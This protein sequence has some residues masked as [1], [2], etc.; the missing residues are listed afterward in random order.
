MPRRGSPSRRAPSTPTIRASRFSPRRSAHNARRAVLDKAQR[1]AAGGDVAGALAVLDGAA[2]G[3]QRSTLVEEA[4][5]Q[6]AQQQ[7]DAR[8]AEYLSRGH[9]AL[10]RG[11]LIA[12]V[13]GQRA[14]LHRVG[15]GA[16]ARRCRRA[17]V[18]AG[19]DRTPAA[20]SPPGAR[21]QECRAGGHL[22]RGGGRCLG[23]TPHRWRAARQRAAAAQRRA[24][25]SSS[26]GSRPP[27]SSAS[28]QVR[29]SSRPPTAR[30]STSLS[31]CSR[32]PHDPATQ[33]ARSAY[34][35][36]LL[37]EARNALGAQDFPGARRWLAEARA[38]VRRRG[39]R[40][41]GSTRRWRWRRTRRSRRGS[42]VNASSLTRTH[43]V[44]PQFPDIARTRGIDGWVDCSSS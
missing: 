38:A 30:S 33:R 12:P 19:S 5:E 44:A 25:P 27:S 37:D 2:H 13:E 8:V 15:A 7:L 22:D 31:S 42:F 17:A 35:A 18:D 41:P 10:A 4:R 9:E 6:L 20:R 21:R 29:S 1:A 3:A 23:R 24:Q 34:G 26:P 40:G 39:R 43:Y 16:R 14:L 28:A 36:R 11:A 32:R